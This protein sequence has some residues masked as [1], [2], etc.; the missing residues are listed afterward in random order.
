MTHLYFADQAEKAIV[1]I[2]ESV[3]EFLAGKC[4]QGKNEELAGL[5]S[6]GNWTHDH[7]ITYERAKSSGYPSEVTSTRTS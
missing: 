1:Q 6:E 2:R 5:L 3:R 4:P 7:S